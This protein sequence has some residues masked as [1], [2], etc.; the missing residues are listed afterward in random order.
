MVPLLHLSQVIPDLTSRVE[1][2]E[3]E[4]RQAREEAVTTHN[5]SQ[6]K[7]TLPHDTH[8]IHA[9]YIH[10]TLHTQYTHITHT[11]RC[12]HNTHTLHTQYTHNT[13]TIHTQYTHNTHTIH[14]HSHNARSVHLHRRSP[15]RSNKTRC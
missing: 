1:R 14:T 4:L 2:L 12:T 11:A 8:T 7:F 9:Q 15:R 6:S 13:H 10:R 3:E 5:A